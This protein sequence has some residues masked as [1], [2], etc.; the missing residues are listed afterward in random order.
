MIL[1]G[2]RLYRDIQLLI[3]LVAMKID[4]VST[5]DLPQ[6]NMYIQYPDLKSGNNM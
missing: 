1:G 6:G 5:L 2:A 4:I 3:I